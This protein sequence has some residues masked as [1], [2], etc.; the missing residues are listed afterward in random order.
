MDSTESRMDSALVHLRR[1]GI[2]IAA[3]ICMTARLGH[4]HCDLALGDPQFAHT[5]QQRGPRDTE[6]RCRTVTASN[7]PA[8][9]PQ[10]VEDVVAFRR[11]KGTNRGWGRGSG[12]PFELV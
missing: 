8:D 5:V 2:Q 12:N 10:D 11:S 9:L 3:C 4:S 7:H 6:A 1:T